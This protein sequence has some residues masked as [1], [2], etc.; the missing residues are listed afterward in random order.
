MASPRFLSVAVIFVLGCTASSSSSLGT[1]GGTADGAAAPDGPTAA[2]DA[3]TAGSP[4]AR[5]ATSD[6]GSCAMALESCLTV[7]CCTGFLCCSGN[8]I[9]VGQAVCY[10][11]MCPY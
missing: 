10:F 2:P 3:T 11:S 8:P 4:D 9:P 1:D 6:A 7:S 5:V